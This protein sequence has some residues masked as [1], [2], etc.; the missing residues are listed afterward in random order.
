MLVEDCCRT[1]TGVGPCWSWSRCLGQERTR[2]GLREVTMHG[3]WM[4]PW[5]C[6]GGSRDR[7]GRGRSNPARARG[8]PGI[9]DRLGVLAVIVVC[10]RE[11]LEAM[12]C[13]GPWHG[14][15]R[16]WPR[17]FVCRGIR[18]L[19]ESEQHACAGLVCTEGGQSRPGSWCSMGMQVVL[20]LGR[21]LGL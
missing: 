12:A 14:V 10:V 13:W 18:E 6:V 21:W 2:E 20:V 15:H 16:G 3:S 7:A 19:C 11:L 1:L 4:K 8:G 9:S 5:A 17:E